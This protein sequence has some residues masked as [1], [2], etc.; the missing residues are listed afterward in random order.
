MERTR[1]KYVIIYVDKLV[2]KMLF[3]SVETAQAYID[4]AMSGNAF[5]NKA[6]KGIEIGE[7]R[8]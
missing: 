4:K 8:Y 7:V 2:C 3:D 1:T 5:A 6:K